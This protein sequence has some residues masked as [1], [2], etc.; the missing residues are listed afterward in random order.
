MKI[1]FVYSLD[2]IQ[3]IQYPINSWAS[4]Q[5]GIS[6]ISSVLKLNSYQ[7]KLLVLGSNSRWKVNINLLKSFIEEFN[8]NLIC[9]TATFSQYNFIK[10]IAEFVKS[11]WPDKFIVIG[12]VHAS[13]NPREVIEGPFDAVCIGEG[14]YPTLEL[15]RQLGKNEFPHGIANLWIKSRDGEIEENEPRGFLQNLDELPFPDREMWKHWIKEQPDDELAMLLGRGCPYDC[16]YCSNHMLGKIASGKYVRMRST[17]NILKEIAFIHNNYP[18]SKI[19]FEIETIAANKNWAL[20]FCSQLKEFNG[21]IDNSISYGC[22]FR[23]SPQSMDEKLF[24]SFKEAN[25]HKI[26]IGLESGSEKIR[27][28]VLNRNYS[29]EDFLNTISI[30]HKYGLNCLI[31]NMIGLPGESYGDHMETVLLNRQCQPYC[32]S[33]GI[34]YPYPGTKLYDTCFNQGLL[35]SPID[36][37]LERSRACL[38]LPAFSKRQIQSSLTWFDYRV[39]KGFR[40]LWKLYISVIRAKINSSPKIKYLLRKIISVMDSREL[41]SQK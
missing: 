30:A 25:F 13:L 41:V 22:N 37:R 7:T 21:T 17:E 19:Y 23:I 2:D 35:K 27:S 5:F 31:Y 6:Y 4:I 20:E 34:F 12:G 11:Q 38:D 36:T 15:C 39:Y 8:P 18:H 9:F 3:S 1:M 10:T 28:E 26:H 40:P 32:H 24:R 33:T 29:N 14:E 16:T